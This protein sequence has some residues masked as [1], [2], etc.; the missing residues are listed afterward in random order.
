M[1]SLTVNSIN[2]RTV[3]DT[4]LLEWDNSLVDFRIPYDRAKYDTVRLYGWFDVPPGGANNGLYFQPTTGTNLDPRLL[5]FMNGGGSNQ[6]WVDPDGA[7]GDAD[8]MYWNAVST[9]VV[10]WQI[11]VT[12]LNSSQGSSDNIWC[13]TPS[14]RV[15]SLLG[16]YGKGFRFLSAQDWNT[17]IG[18]DLNGWRI[19]STLGA[20]NN[21][22]C[23]RLT[24]SKLNVI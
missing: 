13:S 11:D 12:L 5:S 9:G 16:S 2:S 3:G 6:T 23:L 15:F 19:N 17:P 4:T 1:S 8:Q 21:K 20:T 22:G 7:Q 10:R 18:N 24:Y 14:T